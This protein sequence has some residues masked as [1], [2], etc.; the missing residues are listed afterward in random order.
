MQLNPQLQ[1]GTFAT[2]TGLLTATGTET[3]YDTTVTIDFCINGQAYRKTAVTDGVTPTT[4]GN[5]GVAFDRVYANQAS[6]FVWALNA[7]GTVSVYQG[8]IVSMD[9][10]G[11]LLAAL[12]LPSLPNNVC[13]FGYTLFKAGATASAAGL[14]FGTS[15]WDA[16]GLTATTRNLL[17]LPQTPITA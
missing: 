2:N 5:T 12:Q 10:D 3:V 9:A 15:N 16:T 6:I 1:G 11:N 13:A 8:N 4:D 7:S 14:L 17:T